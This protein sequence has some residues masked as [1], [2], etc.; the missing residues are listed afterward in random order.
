M[1]LMTPNALRFAREIRRRCHWPRWQTS[2]KSWRPAWVGDL[3]IRRLQ[4]AIASHQEALLRFGHESDEEFTALAVELSRLNAKFSELREQSTALDLVVQGLDEERASEAAYQLYKSSIDLV[5]SSMGIALSEQEQMLQV[6]AGLQNAQAAQSHFAHSNITLRVLMMGLRMEAAR[7]APEEQ[8]VFLTVADAVQET[9]E[10]IMDTVGVAFA[11]IAAVLAETG[12]ER[13]QLRHLEQSLHGR[14]HANISAIHRELDALQAALAP[15]HEEGL[16]IAALLD[17]TTPTSLR[18]IS[19]LQHQDIVRQKLEHVATGFSDITTH[20]TDGQL[21]QGR[22]K[23]RRRLDHGYLHH[24]ARVQQTHLVAAREEIET[25]GEKVTSSLH[26]LLAL[27]DGLMGQFSRMEEVA[28][29]AFGNFHV[30]EMFAREVEALA[31][32]AD[33][34]RQTNQKVTAL[35]ARITEIVEV[36]SQHLGRHE[37]DVRLV[38]LNAQ[39]AACRMPDAEA[40]NKLAE[41][42]NRVATA[43]AALTDDLTRE[44]NHTLRH[45]EGIKHEADEFLRVISTER[46]A[47]AANAQVVTGKLNRLSTTVRQSAARL[48]QEFA[49]V[50]ASCKALLARL[51]FPSLITTSFGPAETFCLQLSAITQA[52]SQ[53]LSEEAAERLEAHQKRYTMQ[54]ENMAHQAA[55]ATLAAGS[56]AATLGAPEDV[57]LFDPPPAE[58]SPAAPGMIADAAQDNESAALPDVAAI[59]P[60]ATDGTPIDAGNTSPEKPTAASGKAP[61][62]DLGD[63]IELF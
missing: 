35:V 45:L 12:T 30:A 25:A 22:G 13:R 55:L 43:N 62:D 51:C 41:E 8:G 63:G 33:Q 7:V 61:A 26:S 37:Y 47:L 2:L 31:Q 28:E 49:A 59:A 58:A 6:E 18:I 46:S 60:D 57:E 19:A 52:R 42:I 32:I 53:T 14:A 15:C 23:H 9:A 50:H 16:R 24:A 48:N 17:Q 40:L 1:H 20:M 3:R 4:P 29:T 36:F 44:L 38:A 11:H 54:Q 56:A 39:I 27:G 10:K 21:A 5:H 34:G